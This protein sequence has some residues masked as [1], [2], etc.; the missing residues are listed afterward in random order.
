MPRTFFDSCS[1]G[2]TL[3]PLKINGFFWNFA[4]GSSVALQKAMEME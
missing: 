3:P 4:P 1:E 2:L